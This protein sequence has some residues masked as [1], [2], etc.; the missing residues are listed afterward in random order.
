MGI[1]ARYYLAQKGLNVLGIDQFSIPHEKGGHNG[2]SR[3]VRKAYF[4]H[5]SYVP[6]LQR[7]YELW[8]D[9]EKKSGKKL[10]YKT[11]LVYF[12]KPGH[13]VIEGV[14][15][16]ATLFNISLE[17]AE[18]RNAFE[19]FKLP[20]EFIGLFE[21]DAGF[22]IPELT[23]SAYKDL[24]ITS[25]ANIQLNEKVIGWEKQGEVFKVFTDKGSYQ[26]G[27]ILFTAGPWINKLLPAFG[28]QI[29]ITRQ[30]IGWTSFSNINDY[31]IGNFPCWIIADEDPGVY[32][33][34]PAIKNEM[35]FAWHNAATETDP[36]NTNRTVI[37]KETEQLE[38]VLSKY[39]PATG[40]K[41]SRS[42]VCLYDNSPDENF[43]LGQVPG[44]ENAFIGSGFSGHGF[45][46]VPV[47]GEIL[48]D[49]VFSGKSKLDIKFLDPARFS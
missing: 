43:I 10:F 8:E 26:S 45:K 46:F 1:S 34:F 47:I 23:L 27:K 24:A 9:L 12:G 15:H 6:L 44:I 41:I 33:G 30:L 2:E 16:S 42:S 11:G 39:F 18:D 32:Y 3:L 38:S 37:E 17:E 7:A 22:V 29:K 48:S 4:E 21:P 35:K 13:P 49:L 40:C 25:G 5:A 28:E 31:S 14:R 36:D 19:Q 20:P